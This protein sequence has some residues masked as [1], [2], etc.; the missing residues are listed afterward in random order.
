MTEMSKVADS[1]DD[2]PEL[3]QRIREA[4]ITR[5]KL[6][7]FK[8]P[9]VNGHAQEPPPNE[10]GDPG[11]VAPENYGLSEGE[12]YEPDV[13][14]ADKMC[15]P[16]A[17]TSLA[18]WQALQWRECNQKGKPCA[19][20]HNAK[21]GLVNMGI[22]VKHDLFHDATIIGHSNSNRTHDVR[23]LYGELSDPALIGLRSLFSERYGF[24]VGATN[25]YDAVKALAFENCFDHVLDLCDA[26]QALW[27]A[28]RVPRLDRFAPD[29]LNTEDTPL[30]RSVGRKHMVAKC[31]RRASQAANT[32]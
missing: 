27:E 29:Y 19:S 13:P 8:P 14:P 21:V 18:K 15:E 4:G 24:D 30:N 7:A 1:F 11:P 3:R 12:A 16:G 6:S 20:F 10:D 17:G 28:D 5:R 22:T 9:R 31:V 23:P 26:A 25:I 2:D 32:N